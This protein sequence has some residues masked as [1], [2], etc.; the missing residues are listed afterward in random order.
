MRMSP[1]N[2]QL[3]LLCALAAVLMLTPVVSML[4][5]SGRLALQVAYFAVAVLGA[6]AC[7]AS[8]R[9]I[10]MIRGAAGCAFVLAVLV[11]VGAAP[12][13]TLLP[14]AIFLVIFAAVATRLLA[15]VLGGSKVDASEL[16]GAVS[17]YV[18]I[19]ITWGVLYLL[20]E[21]ISPGS[22]SGLGQVGESSDF[23]YFSLV[24]LSTL[25]YGDIVPASRLARSLA[26]LEAMSGQMYLAILMAR[27]VGLWAS[28]RLRDR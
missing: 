11:Q 5:L 19:G 8:R 3:F 28:P 7:G 14:P 17:V 20:L 2:P 21:L 1:P 13:L 15:F 27:L 9:F 25:G 26:A 18:M 23:V 4:G 6:R 10:L 24:T 22:F 16:Y 12:W